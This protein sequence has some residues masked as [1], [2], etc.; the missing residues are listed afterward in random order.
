MLHVLDMQHADVSLR[1]AKSCVTCAQTQVGVGQLGL[2]INL[3]ISSFS[4]I[5]HLFRE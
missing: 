5:V 3:S 1:Q 2:S 4:P